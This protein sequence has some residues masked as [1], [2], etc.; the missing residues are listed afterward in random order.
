MSMLSDRLVRLSEAYVG[1]GTWSEQY[2]D[3]YFAAVR[4]LVDEVGADACLEVALQVSVRERGPLLCVALDVLGVLFDRQAELLPLLLSVTST[5][6]AS[7]DEEVR[8]SVVNALLTA[9]EDDDPGVRDWA[10]FGL[11]VQLDVDSPAIR[12]ALAQRLDDDGGDTAGEAA[13]ALARRGDPRAYDV[14]VTELARPD[15]GNLYVEAAGALGTP[16]LLPL[17][18]DLLTSG[19]QDHEE[20]RP[21]TLDD[22]IRRCAPDT[23]LT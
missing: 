3:E 19:W 1:E 17:L 10:V 14:V 20:P 18:Q 7:S 2:F 12:D 11:G 22:A 5:A 23:A 8:Y 6:L 16:L 21:G 9:F 13:L 15:V 4:A